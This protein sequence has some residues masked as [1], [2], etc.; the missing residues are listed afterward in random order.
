MAGLY[1]HIP[2]RLVQRV[3]DDS[4]YET[5]APS[6][7]SR[8]ETA[9]SRELLYYAEKYAADEQIRTV[10]AGGGRPSLLPIDQVHSLLATVVE[11]FDA[12]AFE[13]ATAEVSP[14]DTPARYIHGLKHMGF[15]R[16]S[17]EVL[18]FF[19]GAL[20]QLNA[21]H[22][23]DEAIRTLRGVREA[24]FES[25]SVDLAFGWPGQ[26]FQQWKA[27]LRQ[28]VEMG[29]P[30]ITIV[31]AASDDDQETQK[32]LAKQME[33]AMT[34]LHSEG[35]DQYELTHFARS[36]HRSVH[37]EN[38]YAHGNYL[39]IGP[40][41][42]TFWWVDRSTEGAAERWANISDVD[43][44]AELLEQR[45]PPVAY[46]QTLNRTSLAEEFIMLR[47]RTN[48][49][50]DLD[51]LRAQYGVDL[52]SSCGDVITRLSEEGLIREEDETIRLTIQGRLVA[53]G[54]TERLMPE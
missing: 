16:V 15:D 3:Y 9:L 30:H 5:H 42:E 17:I 1:L 33:F 31:E 6:D 46:R 25:V 29:V 34:F 47:L 12:S 48:A 20:D 26:S 32:N 53:D 22:S 23:A 37:Q 54:I 13:E 18:S 11:V 36:G 45:Y 40:S 52:R 41:A 14:A 27:T 8:F 10:Y 7:F 39:G 2:F 4:Y 51:E 38:Y 44:Y 28:T 24:G 21:P 49:G 35:Y 43:R 19:P 50:L